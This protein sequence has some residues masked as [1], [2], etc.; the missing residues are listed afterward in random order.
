MIA[1]YSLFTLCKCLC[2]V[3]IIARFYQSVNQRPYT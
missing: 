1:V 2:H 3:C